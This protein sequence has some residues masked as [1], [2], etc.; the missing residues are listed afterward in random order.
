[1]KIF[2]ILITALVLNQNVFATPL[3]GPG[4]NL[5]K[6][7]TQQSQAGS[8]FQSAVAKGDQPAV[9]EKCEENKK[10][11]L[12]NQVGVLLTSDGKAVTDGSGQAVK[13]GN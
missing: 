10:A 9:C 13:T 5:E 1:M 11:M 7:P 2:L 12:S 4:R 6:S 3:E 8:T